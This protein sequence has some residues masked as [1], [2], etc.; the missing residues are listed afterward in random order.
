MN[1]RLQNVLGALAAS[2][3]CLFGMTPAL[4]GNPVSAGFD[5][6]VRERFAL[7]P[8]GTGLGAEA[9]VL[10]T[11]PIP[12]PETENAFIQPATWT[13]DFD[14]CVS[15]GAIAEYRWTVDGNFAGTETG[16][17]DF[18]FEFDIL[19][20]HLVSLTVVDAQMNEATTPLQIDVQDFLIVVLGDSVASGEG[21]PDV[22][23]AQL[24]IDAADGA[25]SDFDVA[26]ISAD[27]ASA[28]LQQAI[29]DVA[30][31]DAV[32]GLQQGYLDAIAADDACSGI[33]ECISTAAML[34]AAA[35]AFVQ[36]LDD[37]GLFGI[38]IEDDPTSI[39]NALE[40][41]ITAAM[42]I[43]DDAQSASDAAQ[44]IL[45]SAESDLDAALAALE[46]TWRNRRCHRSAL[47]GS[48]Q[49]ARQLADSDPHSSVT[50]IHLPCS[51][52]TI[53]TGVI[54]SYDGI[55]PVELDEMTGMLEFATAP[56][57][58]QIDRARELICG[59]S[60]DGSDRQ[61][62]AFLLSVGA[63]DVNFGE[64]IQSCIAGEPCFNH[65][66]PDGA[67]AAS[68]ALLCA[69]VGSFSTA[70]DDFYSMLPV[71]DAEE[72]FLD[73]MNE[74]PAN[75]LDDLPMQYQALQTALSNAFGAGAAG[76]LFLMEYPDL[77][78][79]GN[80]AFCGWEITQ[81]PG[82]QTMN[83]PGVSSAEMIWADTVVQT[84]LTAAMQTAAAVNGWNFVGG[85]ADAFGTHGY[86]AA[87]NWINRLQESYLAQ[88][89]VEGALHPS[90]TGQLVYRD[91]I[92]VE[93][94][95]P[96]T[97]AQG[98]AA[99]ATLVAASRFRRA[100]FRNP[101]RDATPAGP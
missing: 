66:I 65:P 79:D 86:C 94:P 43:R 35:T 14:A 20:A 34:V 59:A 100:R 17:A 31:V 98:V 23:I 92:L 55:D 85:I 87:D 29:E 72:A 97:G 15:M 7:P 88:G 6:V 5:Y 42:T 67:A 30:D 8:L 41:L 25:Q 1:G 16:C 47:S 73:G 75:G 93:L 24:D 18:T 99:V 101:E 27:S 10:Y 28:A 57:P 54:G 48:V 83:L 77:T 40:G 3:L 81:S 58:A 11:N 61:V 21:V 96:G 82:E 52:A 53:E 19:G 49:A 74:P 91:A 51:G 68:F 64:I 2:G 60:C 44:A 63:N 26:Q 90:E 32:F 95:E 22:P 78:R 37:L 89:G 70:C 76:N 71:I 80:G 13:V 38:D 4:A 50:L 9:G 56:L 84:Q 12:A 33:A 69:A 62:D 36:G 39:S 46:P 45:A